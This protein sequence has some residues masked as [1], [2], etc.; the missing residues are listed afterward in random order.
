M[1]WGYKGQQ[2]K[3]AGEARSAAGFRFRTQNKTNRVIK[4]LDAHGNKRVIRRQG[5]MGLTK[6][7]CILS[8]LEM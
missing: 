6:H 1:Q 4:L 3:L 2:N 5:K 7:N 8:A